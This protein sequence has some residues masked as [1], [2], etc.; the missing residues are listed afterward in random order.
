MP[1][2][3][4]STQQELK[5]AVASAAMDE[6]APRLERDTII[7]V[8]TGT[9]ATL[10]IKELGKLKQQFAGAVAS[11]EKSAELLRAEGI[12]VFD[13]NATGPL[14]FYIDGADEITRDL[15]MI[16]GG[17]GALTREKIVAACSTTFI[18]IADE[19][20]LVDELGQFP[21]SVEVIPMARSQVAREL[22]TLGANPVYREGVVTDNGNQILDLYDFMIP[23]PMEMEERLNAIVGTVTN[24]LFA[25]RGADVLLLGRADRVERITL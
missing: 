25:H 12:E 23:A 3:T 1:A 10:F 15:K 16:K 20:K 6:I 7:G 2:I 14:D 4:K 8:G 19:T 24:G 11:S 21:L 5:Q 9:T 18:C 22:V 13:L 17:G